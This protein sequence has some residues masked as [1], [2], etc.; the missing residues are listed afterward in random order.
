M[1]E[2]ESKEKKLHRGTSRVDFIKQPARCTGEKNLLPFP[3]FMHQK[4]GS[5]QICPNKEEK[6]VVTAGVSS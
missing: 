5:E 4:S 3:S 6:G 1:L 2:Q